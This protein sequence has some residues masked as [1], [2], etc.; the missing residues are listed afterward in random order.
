MTKPLTPL[1]QQAKTPVVL[2]RT[3]SK[4]DE[5][6]KKGSIMRY[7]KLRVGR[8]PLDSK[9]PASLSSSSV[10]ASST[11]V[12]V[13]SAPSI[14]K[15]KTASSSSSSSSSSLVASATK[16]ETASLSVSSSASLLAAP[17]TAALSIETAARKK[18]ASSSS[19]AAAA[20]L[21]AYPEYLLCLTL[22]KFGSHL[23]G[24]A[25]ECFNKNNIQLMLEDGDTSQTN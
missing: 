8:Q 11:V 25:Y 19:L 17:I 20:L 16:K 18:M 6:K 7:L 15:K 10:V 24:S 21:A 1:Q 13:L 9:K 22:D 2:P 12:A 5:A 3:R 4:L 23:Q 14:G